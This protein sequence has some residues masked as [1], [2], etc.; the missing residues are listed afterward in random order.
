MC[1]GVQHHANFHCCDKN[2]QVWGAESEGPRVTARSTDNGGVGRVRGRG[3]GSDWITLILHDSLASL[4]PACLE[5]LDG[6]VVLSWSKLTA[7][8]VCW[9]YTVF[10]GTLKWAGEMGESLLSHVCHN[11]PGLSSCLLS[12]GWLWLS[13]EWGINCD[14]ICLTIATKSY[15]KQK[16][17]CVRSVSRNGLTL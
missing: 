10:K 3:G 13:D 6:A 16:V 4:S 15:N 14:I 7:M 5:G 11:Y 2:K 9:Q 1:I 12:G 17:L 8:D